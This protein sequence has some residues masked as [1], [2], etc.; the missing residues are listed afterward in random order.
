MLAMNPWA[1]RLLSWL[2]M[3]ASLSLV[4]STLLA[5]WNGQA[6]AADVGDPGLRAMPDLSARNVLPPW[7]LSGASTGPA[8]VAPPVSVML[9]PLASPSIVSV[10]QS[11]DPG[12]EGSPVIVTIT[13]LDTTHYSF[14]WDNDGS[15]EVISQTNAS[16]SNTWAD[17]ATYTVGVQACDDTEC[18]TT[19]TGVTVDNVV[20]VASASNDGPVGE[21]SLATVTASQT[22]P[23]TADTFVYSFD[24]DNDG[25]YEVISQTNV[26]ASNTWVDD[27][28]YTV[29]VQVCDDDGGCDTVTTDVIVNNVVPVA[30]AS[31]DGPVNEGSLVTVTA[32]QTDPGTADTFVYSFDWDNDGSYEVISQTNALASNTWYDDGTYT[33]GVQVCDDDGGCDTVTTGVI[34]NNVAPVVTARAGLTADEGQPLN[35]QVATFTDAGSDDT[36]TAQINWGDGTVGSGTVGAGVVTGAHTYADDDVYTVVVTVIDDDGGWDLD[37]FA[38]TVHNV[39]P[40]VTARADLT[41]DEGQPLNLQ[42]A[43]FT[44]VGSGDTHTAQINWGDGTVGSGT[45]GAG[46]VTG[47]HTYA[48]NGVYTV[49]VTV[50]DDDGGSDSD[51]FEVTVYNVAPVVT[52]ATGLVVDEG[53]S[54]NRQV[55]TFT[56]AGTADTHTAEINWGDGT[57]GAGIVGAGTIRGAHTYVVDGFYTVVITVTDKDAAF[58]SDSSVITVHNVPP[59]LGLSVSY[60]SNTPYPGKRITYTLGYANTGGSPAQGVVLTATLPQGTS[61]VGQ[62]WV[63]VGGGSY[64]YAVGTV[65]VGGSGSVPFI[66]RVNSTGDG[67]FPPGLTSLQ[68]TF[69]IADNRQNGDEF[70]KLDNVATSFIGIPDLVIDEIKVTPDPPVPNQSVTFTVVIRNRGTGL[71]ANPNVPGGGGFYI[72]LFI[73]PEPAP[74]SYPW[75]AWGDLYKFTTALPAGGTRDIAFVLPG[76]L[77]NQDHDVY[78]KV[79]NFLDPGLALWQRNSLVPESDEQ[80]NVTWTPVSR[81]EPESTIFLPIVL[82]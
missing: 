68:S 61:Y 20:P 17:D 7:F 10:S 16:A 29:D 45:V 67:R 33:V 39:A 31:N 28:T 1:R 63:P 49:A 34:V 18:V 81:P 72:D 76:G 27:G 47:A 52:A 55:A 23:G 15:Y 5:G 80:N 4:F 8:S 57:V 65:G 51:T 13:A 70:N 48:D 25:G 42:V 30:A 44:D 21:G 59:A 58:D 11:P 19:T 43:T 26:L 69:T 40:V 35:L 24:W 54:F 32:S 75:N 64:T 36:H 6:L 41:A 77:S 12:N 71:G 22:D 60:D 14:D 78:A 38:I 73:D 53:Q 82:R 79:D 56:D 74:W 2:R 62:G 50:T 66:V 3:C 9:A 37:T 46:A